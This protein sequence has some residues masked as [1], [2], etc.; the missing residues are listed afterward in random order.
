[1]SGI[2]LIE[3][4]EEKV[5]RY[6][7]TLKAIHS[8]KLEGADFGEWAR[9]TCE[10]VLE[11]LFPECPFCGTAIHEG[12]DASGDLSDSTEIIE[13]RKSVFGGRLS[14][15]LLSRSAA[16]PKRAKGTRNSR[17]SGGSLT[18]RR[19]GISDRKK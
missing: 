11:G 5:A 13:L 6:E 1:M 15:A 19:R 18:K 8:S 2:D 17:Q 14:C 9:R 16:R 3:T 7:L 12:G 10:E 4:S